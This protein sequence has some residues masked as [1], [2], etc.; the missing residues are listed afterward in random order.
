VLPACDGPTHAYV[1][2]SPACW[3][4]YG[5]ASTLSWGRPDGLPLERLVVNAYG[6]QHPGVREVRAVQSVAVH[7]MGL[8]M[9]LERGEEP[10][11]LRVRDRKRRRKT[12][13]LHWLEPPSPIGTLTVRE[14]VGA[15]GPDD[16][17]ARVEAWARDVWA[18][19]GPHHETV[20]SWLDIASAGTS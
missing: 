1:G 16:H 10:Q 13:D 3:R 18:A 5:Q 4:L 19:W 14:A 17:A 12:V 20:R 15:R 6:A 9:I 11:I 8:C 7:L 2:A